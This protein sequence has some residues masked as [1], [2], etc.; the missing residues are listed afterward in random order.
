M[1]IDT[2][3][4][5]TSA[6]V[7]RC[8]AT[9][10]SLLIVTQPQLTGYYNVCI[11][12]CLKASATLL[13]RPPLNKL[14]E[15][16][17]Y[18]KYATKELYTQQVSAWKRTSSHSFILVFS[19]FPLFPLFLYL[20]PCYFWQLKSLDFLPRHHKKGDWRTYRMS[21]DSSLS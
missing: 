12:P 15:G 7:P 21:L 16:V 6:H 4:A 19:Y 14:E 8:R 13:F 3:V 20:P 10:G 17:S 1:H 11:W 2:T 5:L 9:V 18:K